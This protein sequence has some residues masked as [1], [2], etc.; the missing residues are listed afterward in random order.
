[1]RLKEEAIQV[2]KKIWADY[3]WFLDADVFIV[4]N[5]TLKHLVSKKKDL[6]APMLLSGGLYRYKNKY[7]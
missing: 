7:T 5:Q 3:I 2:S 4:N 1:M 6:V